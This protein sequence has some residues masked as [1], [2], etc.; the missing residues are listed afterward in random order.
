[1]RRRFDAFKSTMGRPNYRTLSCTEDFAVKTNIDDS[2]L[3]KL[4]HKPHQ[5]RRIQYAIPHTVASYLSPPGLGNKS[6]I[7]EHLNCI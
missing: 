1:M 2:N 6:R 7:Q 3:V 5:G 4:S